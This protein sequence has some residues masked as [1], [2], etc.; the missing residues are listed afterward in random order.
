MEPGFVI[1]LSGPSGVGKGTVNAQLSLRQP[2]I[3]QSISMTTRA[4]RVGETNGKD[5]FFV[6]PEEFVQQRDQGDLLEWAEYV[7]NYYGTPKRFVED[8]VAAGHIVMLEIE[9][10]GAMQLK[11]TLRDGVFIFLVP[12]HFDELA[13]RIRG[14]GAE[15]DTQIAERIER[16]RQEL[17]QI[18]SYEYVV[19]NDMVEEAVDH[20]EA[21][22]LAERRKVVR[23]IGLQLRFAP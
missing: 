2:D 22:L 3:V 8:H 17:T 6:S 4:Q 1:V 11:E 18:A 10:Q 21:I 20:I 19:V 13:E 5:Y 16:A 23:N 14:R 12:P 7:H 9:T 15:N